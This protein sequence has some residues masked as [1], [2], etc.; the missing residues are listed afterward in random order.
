M[1]FEQTTEGI[2][3]PQDIATTSLT[4]VAQTMGTMRAPSAYVWNDGDKFP[5]GF[6]VTKL[7][8]TDYWTLRKRSAQLFKENLY[9]RG[10]IRRL[11]TNIINTGIAPEACPDESIIGVEE[12]SLNEWAENVESLFHVWAKDPMSCDYKHGMTFG[13]LQRAV[14]AEALIEGDILVTLIPDQ[15]TGVPRVNLTSGERVVTPLGQNLRLTQGHE[16]QHGVELNAQGRQVAYWVKSLK[17]GEVRRVPAVSRRTGRRVAWLVY[18]CDKRMD[19]VRGEPL[20]S[21]ILQSLKE[22]DRYRDSTQ[23]K[24]VINSMLAMFI[25]KSE[26][27]QGTRPVSAGSV[28]RGS[29]TT[30]DDGGTPRK[31]N[32]ADQ[33]PGVVYEELQTGEEPVLKGGEGTDVNFGTFEEAIIQGVSWALEIPPEIARLAFSNNYSASQAAIN[34]FKIFIN[35]EWGVMGETF[36]QVIYNDWLLSQV[37]RGRVSAPGLL[38]A[39]RE[40]NARE[41]FVAWTLADWYGSIKP[42]TDMLKQARGS[43]ELIKEGWT[44]NA[45]ESRVLTGTKYSKNISRLKRENELKAEAMRPLAEFEQEFG[46]SVEEVQAR[47]QETQP[48]ATDLDELIEQILD[49]GSLNA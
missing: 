40:A 36:C 34:E 43:Q 7:F 6:G 42:S 9:A 23:R 17:D 31:F 10:L 27:K 44:T 21:I 2:L 28:R 20:L 49:E 39:W 37:L 25:K 30:Q 45:R 16:I 46:M 48:E 26:D 35:K 15:V 47:G 13:A 38:E 19:E 24:A 12:D 32:I 5:G 18:G 3:I 1:L 4:P 29:V 41:E 11:I 8:E 22:I 33:I 14:K